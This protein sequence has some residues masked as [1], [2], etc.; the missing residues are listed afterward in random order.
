MTVITKL[1]ITKRGNATKL[2]AALTWLWSGPFWPSY[3]VF[4]SSVRLG[5]NRF[6]WGIPSSLPRKDRAFHDTPTSLVGLEKILRRKPV[7]FVSAPWHGITIEQKV[8]L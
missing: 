4:A 3:S 6:S 2:I 8:L 1:V 7:N 5:C